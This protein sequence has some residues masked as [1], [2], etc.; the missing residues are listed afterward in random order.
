MCQQRKGFSYF[1]KNCSPYDPVLF[2]LDKRRK[3]PHNLRKEWEKRAQME[4]KKE[5]FSP[6]RILVEGGSGEIIEKKSRFIATTMPVSS[7]EEAAAFIESMRK[8]YYDA[9]H[10]CPAYIIGRNQELTRCSDDKEPAGTAGRPILEVLLKEKLTGVAIVV[11]RYFGGVLLGTGG[12]VRAYTEAAKA[13]L[14]ASGTAWMRYGI[15]VSIQ[16]DYTDLGKVQFLLAGK[17]LETECIYTENVE[18]RVR[19]PIEMKENVLK[20]VTEGTAG[21]AGFQILEEGYYRDFT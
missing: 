15:L 10:N 8:K 17:G 4:E 11:T 2:S 20:E 13:G 5:Q 1:I 19:I 7:E 14:A 18:I 3:L 21:R 12:L 16:T 9:R 6:Y